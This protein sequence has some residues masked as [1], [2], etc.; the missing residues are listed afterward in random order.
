MPRY[1][2]IG[3]GFAVDATGYWRMRWSSCS[4]A[5]L[6]LWISFAGEVKQRTRVVLR[7][8]RQSVTASG[9]LR[10]MS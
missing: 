7:R 10:G 3:L 5:A 8:W 9:P 6:L 2:A 4:F 1:G